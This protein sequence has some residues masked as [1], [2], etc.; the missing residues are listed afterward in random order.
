MTVYQENETV[1]NSLIEPNPVI[2]AFKQDIDRTLIRKNLQ[3]SYEERLLKIMALQR[4]AKELSQAG[5][6]VRRSRVRA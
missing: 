6:R 1:Q 4:F 2:E 3:L 5:Q